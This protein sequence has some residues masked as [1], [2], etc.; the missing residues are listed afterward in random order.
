MPSF[1]AL[2]CWRWETSSFEGSLP[3][4]GDLLERVQYF[5]YYGLVQSLITDLWTLFQTQFIGMYINYLYTK[6]RMPD[7]SGSLIS[8][9]KR[10]ILWHAD[11]L[12]GNDHVIGDDTKA[13]AWQLP[14]NNNR[15][16]VFSARSLSNNW[17]ATDKRH[18]L[19]SPCWGVISRPIGATSYFCDSRQPVRMWAWK[20]M[21]LLDLSPGNDW[22]RHSRLRTLSTCY[23]EL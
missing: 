4:S 19:C 6:F 20:Q 9:T 1:I 23:N 13:I 11:A 16:M 21:T 12:L 17:T 2:L 10:H 15:G 8:Q 18:F 3:I 14:A 5:V 7:S 22:W